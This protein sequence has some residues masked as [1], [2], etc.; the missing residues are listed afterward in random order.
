MPSISTATA[1]PISGIRCPMRWRRPP[2]NCGTKAGSAACAGPTKC[3]A[4]ADRRLH[5]RRAGPYAPIGEWLKR[6]FVPAYGRA[7]S[8]GRARRAGFAGA[9]RPGSTAR[10]SSPP[11]TTSCIKEY[12]FSDLYVLF[13]G[14]LADRSPIAAARRRSRRRWGKV[15][16]LPTADL[17]RMQE[18]SPRAAITTTRSTARPA[19]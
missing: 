5:H 18:S 12:N 8:R 14:H 13:V 6:G 7:L 15:A 11:R 2:S 4:P 16:Q 1:M 19:C 3:V 17:V 10:R 9:A